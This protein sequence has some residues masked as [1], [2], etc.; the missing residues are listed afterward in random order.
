MVWHR[1]LAALSYAA[2]AAMR[3]SQR[4]K[5]ATCW[6]GHASLLDTLFPI[7][8]AFLHAAWETRS[9][10]YGSSGDSRNGQGERL[11]GL[12]EVG[13]CLE[14]GGHSGPLRRKICRDGHSVEGSAC[15]LGEQ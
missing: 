3:T 8:D 5:E 2:A 6:R 1:D 11:V 10:G 4:S 14:E 9:K 12:R 15:T 13:F 7:V